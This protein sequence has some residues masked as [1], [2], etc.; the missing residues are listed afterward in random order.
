MKKR[1]RKLPDWEDDNPFITIAVLLENEK[2]AV[3]TIVSEIEQNGIY[4]WDKYGRFGLA[5][6]LDKDRVL[7]LLEKY[8]E[9]QETP[10]QEQSFEESR[11]PIDRWG[12]CSDNA[13]GHFG[14]AAEILPDFEKIRQTQEA[15][16]AEELEVSDLNSDEAEK[17]FHDDHSSSSH[18][19]NNLSDNLTHDPQ[20]HQCNIFLAMKNLTA[21]EISITFVGDKT[22]S[23]I[24][25]NNLLEISVRGETKHVALAAL[26]LI[27]LH[28]KRL[29]SQ[30]A[31]LLGMIQKKRLT[32]ISSN[33]KKISRL[34]TIFR[35]YLGID[36][37]PF[38]PYR[39]NVGWEPRFKIYDKRGAVD[40]RARQEGERRSISYDDQSKYSS[41]ELGATSQMHQFL[42]SE[43]D[44][45]AE[46]LKNH[47]PSY[48]R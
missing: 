43:N 20:K 18:A 5:S 28:R 6:G 9:W 17:V 34:R 24:G 41:N 27:D 42:E 31:V 32:N 38:D 1:R 12:C 37:D 29:N 47:D 40:E 44:D 21:D 30:C 14:W 19:Q 2:I 35:R 48:K 23:G 39:K 26:D 36:D 33:K 7:H 25:V 3:A 46:W 10:I 45:T 13:Y 8:Y 15:F 4:T 16:N 22:E 11:S